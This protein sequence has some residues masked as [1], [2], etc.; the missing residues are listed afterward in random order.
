MNPINKRLLFTFVFFISFINVK[1][2][3]DRYDWSIKLGAG[4]S[5]IKT[6]GNTNA[7][8]GNSQGGFYFVSAGYKNFLISLKLNG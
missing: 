1:S 5:W 2:Q 8:L 4:P 7:W 6:N 3:T